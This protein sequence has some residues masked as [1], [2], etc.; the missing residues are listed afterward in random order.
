MKRVKIMLLSFALLAVVSGALA[1][2][3]KFGPLVTCYTTTTQFTN[4]CAEIGSFLKAGNT[5]IYTTPPVNLN[6]V[7]QCLFKLDGI[8]R[9]TCPNTIKA[10]TN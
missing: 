6:G 3:A 4:A 9:L 8:T 5:N 7:D 10:I 2:K 1:F